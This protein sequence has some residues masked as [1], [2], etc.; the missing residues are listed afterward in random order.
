[1]SS[2]TFPYKAKPIH[3]AELGTESSIAFRDQNFVDRRF[4]DGQSETRRS[5]EE[6][7]IPF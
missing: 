5:Q 4:E 2:S 6:A 7:S 3:G 1:M